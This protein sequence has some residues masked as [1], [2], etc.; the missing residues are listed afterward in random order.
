MVSFYLEYNDINKINFWVYFMI[1]GKGERERE[2]KKRGIIG[3]YLIMFEICYNL[4][5]ILDRV[6]KNGW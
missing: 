4:I 2:E 3:L 6:I 5:I 1:K